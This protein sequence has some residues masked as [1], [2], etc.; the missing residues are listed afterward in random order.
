MHHT[1][2]GEVSSAKTHSPARSHLTVHRDIAI[3]LDLQREA[4]GVQNGLGQPPNVLQVLVRSID[5]GINLLLHQV[6]PAH[7]HSEKRAGRG[8]GQL[9]EG[10]GQEFARLPHFGEGA[11][12]LELHLQLGLETGEV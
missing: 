4:T 11:N 12:Y 1:L 6:P 3:A 9:E 7:V 10:G 5:D 8:R 2:A